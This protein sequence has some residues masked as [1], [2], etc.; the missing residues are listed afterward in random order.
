MNATLEGILIEVDADLET[1]ADILAGLLR[2][3]SEDNAITYAA[4]TFALALLPPEVLI[5][6]A[7][8]GIVRAAKVKL[9][10]DAKTDG[11]V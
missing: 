8:A 5:D 3:E 9:A 7:F 1:Q 2:D 11:D 4:L 10:E 6:L